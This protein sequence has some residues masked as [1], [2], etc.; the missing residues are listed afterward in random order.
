MAL[1]EEPKRE[2]LSLASVLRP[3]SHPRAMYRR[4][5]LRY[6][7][8]TSCRLASPLPP[9]PGPPGP[10][11]LDAN[12]ASR[13]PPL[14]DST[15]HV[16]FSGV[17]NPQ[18]SSRYDQHWQWPVSVRDFPLSPS[19]QLKSNS[20]LKPAGT[21]PRKSRKCREA[22]TRLSPEPHQR[23]PHPLCSAKPRP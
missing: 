9:P 15:R 3:S 5:R 16:R 11:R 20:N 14:T 8:D 2:P 18:R 23:D 21:V 17:T 6:T 22:R 7:S 1:V 12:A 10:R 19:P 13:D 4:G